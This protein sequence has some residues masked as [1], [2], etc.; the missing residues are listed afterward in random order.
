M[1]KATCVIGCDEHFPYELTCPRCGSEIDL[2]ELEDAETC[3]KLCGYVV[4][5]HEK[6][7]N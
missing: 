1:L 4:F 5:D 7:I 6:Y 2:T 3:C